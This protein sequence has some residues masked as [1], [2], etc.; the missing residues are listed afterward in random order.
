MKK[1]QVK[2]LEME[3]YNIWKILWMGLTADYTLQKKKKIS[4]LGGIAIQ[5]KTKR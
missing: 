2:L 1:T 4:E 3:K 5:N